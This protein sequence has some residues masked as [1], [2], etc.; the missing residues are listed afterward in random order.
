MAALH[1][2]PGVALARFFRVV[3]AGVPA[4]RGRI[5]Q[6]IRAGQRHQARAFGIPL[7]PADEQAELADRGLDRLEAEIARGE[8]E[9]LVERWIVGDVHF[10]IFSTNIFCSIEDDGGI[11]IEA[12]GT[13]LE[14]RSDDDKFQF[15]G[16][17]A[18]ARGARSRDRFRAIEL[19]DVFVLAEIRAVVQLLQQHEP[20]AGRSGFAQA[21]F[22]RVEVGVGA[23]AVGLL[24]QR[25]AQC[26][27]H[28]NTPLGSC[29]VMQCRL[30]FC[31]IN[32]RHGIATISRPGWAA[33]MM[34]TAS[35]SAAS[36]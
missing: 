3:V 22:D 23:A 1:G 14:Q 32:G 17:R 20:G 34:R 21:G 31:Q 13:A 24:Q 6:Q 26:L 25:D 27:V 16:E 4:D 8:V 9:L 10:A 18:E 19:G 5:E 12:G 28:F 7:V 33:P 11:V 29:M 30:P 15:G 2:D 36:P 35:A